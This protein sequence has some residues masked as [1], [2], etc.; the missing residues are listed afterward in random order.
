MESKYT[1][2]ED[3]DN[4]P[5]P[6]FAQ[7][8]IPSSLSHDDAKKLI[9]QYNSPLGPYNGEFISNEREEIFN[10]GFITTKQPEITLSN[11][12]IEYISK[13]VADILKVSSSE[14]V[15]HEYIDITKKFSDIEREFNILRENT[16]KYM[17]ENKYLRQKLEEI[18]LI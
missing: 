9:K 7:K 11:D 15:L 3:E 12:I 14:E 4:D 1:L 6:M 13:K 16:N 17:K 8:T 2:D 18:L 5:I 10:D